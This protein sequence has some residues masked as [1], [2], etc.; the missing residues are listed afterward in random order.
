MM[1]KK[2]VY[3]LLIC[4]LLGESCA[5]AASY[6]AP[7]PA[8][9]FQSSGYAVQPW[10]PGMAMAAYQKAYAM[11]FEIWRP[12][13]LPAGWYATFDGFPVAQVAENRWVYGKIGMD[14]AM[15]PTDI[16]VGSVVPSD[17]PGLARVAQ[18]L[19][20]SRY[21]DDTEFWKIA[22]YRCDRMG[23]LNDP[24][25]KTAIAWNSQKPAVWLWLGDRWKR[26]APSS[27]EY[28]WQALRRY[29]P[30]LGEQLRLKNVW[31]LGEGDELADAAR[32]MGMLWVGAIYLRDLEGSRDS[33]SNDGTTGK[34]SDGLFDGNKD[35]GGGNNGGGGG[36]NWDVE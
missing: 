6:P 15:S 30:W 25:V 34:T 12:S 7:Y 19:G 23:Y 1:M 26:I 28:T 16:L 33:G 22:G 17:V 3:A 27:G 11:N 21:L 4:L 14:G 36:G 24:V 20:R 13:G 8:P 9:G 2:M 18:A 32:R 31:W 35:S 29:R 5:H 10:T